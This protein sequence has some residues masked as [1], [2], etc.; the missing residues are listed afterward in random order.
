MLFTPK[1]NRRSAIFDSF[2]YD[3][4]GWFL[5]IFELDIDSDSVN[6]S[7]AFTSVKKKF[8]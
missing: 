5:K 4:L 1:L 2:K 6:E 7:N 3:D 8:I